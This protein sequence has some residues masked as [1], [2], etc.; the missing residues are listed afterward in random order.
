MPTTDNKSVKRLIYNSVVK[1]GLKCLGSAFPDIHMSTPSK[2]TDRFLEYPF[3]FEHLPTEKGKLLDIGSSGSFFPL[4]AAALGYQVTG[5]DIRPYEILNK[6][7]FK[8]FEFALRD[9][10]QTPFN[11]DEFDIITCISTIEHVGLGGRYGAVENERADLDMAQVFL[12]I[13]RPGGTALITV[14]F[15]QGEVIAPYHRIYD[16]DRIQKLTQG[17]NTVTERYYTFDSDEDWIEATAEEAE[18]LKGSADR[19]GLALLE[20]KKLKQSTVRD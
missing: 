17:F 1:V 2:P 8:N 12:N 6:L 15:G 7:T 20:L 9:V 19:Y 4:M 18:K 11:N 5:C 3:V 10:L 16:R 13:L 14:P